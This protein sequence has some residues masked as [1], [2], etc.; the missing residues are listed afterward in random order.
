MAVKGAE[1][2]VWARVPR[3]RCGVSARPGI[4]R[5][6]ACTASLRAPLW[7][8]AVINP[9]DIL[10]PVEPV[11][12]LTSFH[13][14]GNLPARKREPLGGSPGGA[15]LGQPSA[16]RGRVFGLDSWVEMAAGG[17]EGGVGGFLAVTLGPSPSRFVL[18]WGIWAR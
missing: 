3:G 2:K 12:F 10:D 18:S 7:L 14:K 13:R 1:G 6:P 15:G 9:F 8:L 16:E 5:M 11:L 17:Q 4:T